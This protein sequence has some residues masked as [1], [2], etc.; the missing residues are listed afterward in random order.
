MG[1]DGGRHWGVVKVV[2]TGMGCFNFFI[3]VGTSD[4]PLLD[5]LP[6]SYVSPLPFPFL[7]SIAVSQNQ[8]MDN[9]NKSIDKRVTF[10]CNLEC[11]G[12]MAS[13]LVIRAAYFY[14]GVQKREGRAMLAGCLVNGILSVI[15]I[16]VMSVSTA[17][18]LSRSDGIIQNKEESKSHA[19]S[20][21][22][23]FIAL[24]YICVSALAINMTLI[25]CLA[26]TS[27]KHHFAYLEYY[28]K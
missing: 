15:A 10:Q 4:R 28:S 16:D 3:S 23:S 18:T 7:N 5:P 2:Q 1:S 21:K 6:H 22:I 12:V 13:F 8:G 11:V 25:H 26:I 19:S 14:K 20:G 17:P 9:L 24:L 27:I